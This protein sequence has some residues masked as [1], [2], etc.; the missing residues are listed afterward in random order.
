MQKAFFFNNIETKF[1]SK[2]KKIVLYFIIY[3]IQFIITF[4][5]IHL[6]FIRK[7]ILKKKK[8]YKKYRTILPKF[9]YV[10]CI[11][12]YNYRVNNINEKR[13]KNLTLP[14]VLDTSKITEN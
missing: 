13:A 2:I 1:R 10:K 3:F 8:L 9:N 4:I 11:E 5:L 6:N 7:K 14:K 12:V